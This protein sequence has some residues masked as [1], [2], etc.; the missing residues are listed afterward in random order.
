LL[1]NKTGT[2]KGVRAEAGAL[3][4]ENRA[5]AYAVSIQFNDDGLAARL[6]VLDAMRTVGFDLLEYVH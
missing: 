5:V 1:I 4:G 6:R 3:R 2:D